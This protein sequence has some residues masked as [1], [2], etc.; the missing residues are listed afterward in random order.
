MKR[1]S[2]KLMK[3]SVWLAVLLVVA[4]VI[5]AYALP[6]EKVFGKSAISVL[7]LPAA[8]VNANAVLLGDYYSRIDTATKIGG[9][10]DDSSTRT[11]ILDQLI[12]NKIQELLLA[13]NNLQTST[14]DTDQLY[15]YLQKSTQEQNLAASYG[16]SEAEFKQD[17]VRPDL[18][19][20]KLAVWLSSNRSLNKDA[21][22]K[23]DQAKA[24]L[25][26]GTSFDVVAKNYSDDAKSAKIGGDLGFVGYQDV[27]PEI[28]AELQQTPDNKVHVI[29]SRFGIH[30]YQVTEKDN[31]GLDNST[32]YHLKHIFIKTADF[33]QWFEQQ[34]KNYS[35]M[36]L[37]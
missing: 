8:F 17:I 27:V 5:Q 12:D 4:F 11:A 32:R 20:T 6:P 7:P 36:K 16:M 25:Q 2:V 24:D 35:I 26:S 23:F 14:S 21:Y 31:K 33:N 9:V 28:Y 18:V 3:V 19:Q 22:K 15:S 37:I 29:Y 34:K 30:I 1:K 13:R 10:K